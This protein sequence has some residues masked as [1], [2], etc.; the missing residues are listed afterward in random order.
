MEAEIQDEYEVYRP[1]GADA[2]M[3]EQEERYEIAQ[4]DSEPEV[5]GLMFYHTDLYDSNSG[6]EIFPED[7]QQQQAEEGIV[8]E[9]TKEEFVSSPEQ[10]Q[11][12]LQKEVDD[13]AKQYG[14]SEDKEEEEIKFFTSKTFRHQDHSPTKYINP[15]AQ[16]S[17]AVPIPKK[18]SETIDQGSG[19]QSPGN[20]NDGQ[21]CENEG[22]YLEQEIESHINEEK[23]LKNGTQQQGETF[24]HLDGQPIHG[25]PEHED[26]K[27]KVEGHKDGHFGQPDYK[28]DPVSMKSN[29]HMSD[30]SEAAEPP[31]IFCITCNTPVRAFEKLFGFHKEHDVTQIK[32][33]VDSIKEET[34]KKMCKLEEQIVQMENFASHLE[35]IFITV[36]ENC[37]RQEQNFEMHYN[38]IMDAL[39]QKHEE[40]VQALGEEKRLKLE[41]LFEQLVDCGKCLDTSKDLMETIQDLFKGKEK[42]DFIK[43]ALQTTNRLNEYFNTDVNLNISTDAEFANNTIEFS[44][45]EQLLDSINTVP[46]PSAPVINPQAPNSATATSLRVCWSLFSD[47]TVESYQLYYKPVSDGTPGEDQEEFMIRAKETYC[48]VNSLMPNTQYEFWV[49]A[50]NTT[51]KSPASESAVYVTVPSPP[52]IKREDCRSCDNA[53]LICWQSGNINPVDSY[54]VEIYKVTNEVNEAFLT[55][56]IVGIPICESL[57][58]LKPNETYHISVK[59]VNVGGPSESS[60]YVSIHTTGTFFHLNKET[61][62]PLLSISGNGFTISCNEEE[63]LADLTYNS[64]SFTRSIAVMANLI[65]YKGRHYW[66]VEVDEDTEYRIGVAYED[67]NRNSLIGANNT[68]WCFRHVLTPARHKYEF[69]HCGISP[70]IRITIPPSRIGVL[71]DYDREKLSFFNMEIHQHLFTF[72]CH[73]Q[74]LVHPCFAL[75]KPGRIHI[76]NGIPIPGSVM[77]P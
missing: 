40:K 44:E 18:D 13:L 61:A 6:L 37:V 23:N 35:E 57:I 20:K 60:R 39:A 62:H 16:R 70:D 42:V 75:E 10:I 67:T 14:L 1:E 24:V 48:M 71:L 22:K 76:H 12:N 7:F 4:E 5:E 64:D 32:A 74:H 38:E 19:N 69:L 41:S 17:L 3:K 9:A 55:E 53:A 54:T 43:I 66:E 26:H 56:S 45:V 63:S 15:Y 29:N 51:G 72:D 34:H 49:V 65:P 77:L 36:D 28:E 11:L 31:D 8:P 46:A 52:I 27:G 33:A 25:H 68:S 50:V 30:E 73:F 47:D 2:A 59:A 58:Q 21:S